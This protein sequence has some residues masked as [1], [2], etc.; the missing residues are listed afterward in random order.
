MKTLLAVLLLLISSIGYSQTD[1]TSIKLEQYKEMFSK[2]LI[3]ATEY[4]ALKGKLLGL[5]EKQTQSLPQK[6]TIVNTP[7]YEARYKSKNIVGGL[8]T[9]IGA[10]CFIGDFAYIAAT[11]DKLTKEQRKPTIIGLSVSSGVFLVTG[12]TLLVVGDH[13]RNIYYKNKKALSLKLNRDGV[14]FAFKF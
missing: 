5:P 3:T 11:K 1:S 6:I 13:E 14:G 8:F 9:G 4:E 12:A 7:N 2:G 10:S